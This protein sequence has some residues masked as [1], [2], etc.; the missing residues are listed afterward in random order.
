VIQENLRY[1]PED[2]LRKLLFEN[3]ARVYGI[4]AEWTIGSAIVA[5][6]RRAARLSHEL[7]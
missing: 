1:V 2:I 3:A 4:S 6:D 5:G 7:Y